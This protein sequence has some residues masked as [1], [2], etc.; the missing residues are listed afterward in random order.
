M[1]SRWG[2]I[3]QTSHYSCQLKT[4]ARWHKVT[5]TRRSVH[6]EFILKRAACRNIVINIRAD[7]WGH[8]RDSQYSR[9]NTLSL[10]SLFLHLSP[11]NLLLSFHLTPISLHPLSLY[12]GQCERLT[13]CCWWHSMPRLCTW[14]CVPPL[15]ASGNG[16]WWIKVDHHMQT[17]RLHETGAGASWH[18]CYFWSDVFASLCH[19]C[20]DLS[21]NLHIF[22]LFTDFFLLSAFALTSF[23]AQMENVQHTNLFLKTSNYFGT[24]ELCCFLFFLLPISQQ[25]H[26]YQ[27]LPLADL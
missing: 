18:S 20:H 2:I 25:I 7:S 16:L 14:V 15:C 24:S 10:L 1:R 17:H 13:R 21:A 22:M 4:E 9:T 6:T 26:K 8:F 3:S 23:N 12:V 11:F 19:A 5:G 27:K